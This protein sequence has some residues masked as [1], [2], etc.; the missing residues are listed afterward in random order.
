MKVE[1]KQITDQLTTACNFGD[2][3][4]VAAVVDEQNDNEIL[5]RNLVKENED[6]TITSIND[7]IFKDIKALMLFCLWKRF[8]H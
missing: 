5:G 4:K 6:G 8:T 7:T 1:L 3:V 2:N